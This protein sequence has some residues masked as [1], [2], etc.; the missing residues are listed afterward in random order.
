M[1]NETK[2]KVWLRL[3]WK[4]ISWNY[5][6]KCTKTKNKLLLKCQSPLE[7]CIQF[8]NER[9]GEV[10]GDSC[11]LFQLIFYNTSLKIKKNIYC[12]VTVL[13]HFCR[14]PLQPPDGVII[15]K[16]LILDLGI[17]GP[18]PFNCFT[19]QQMFG[20]VW[21]LCGKIRCTF[22][23]EL[24]LACFLIFLNFSLVTFE[25]C[26]LVYVNPVENTYK[27]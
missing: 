19:P 20:Q 25:T 17:F 14:Y 26:L 9:R 3:L 22:T 18:A 16:N 10:V 15:R 8:I 6:G 13:G 2:K 11:P 24:I 27:F 12:S 21:Q 5:F 7:S 23:F 4:C 1:Q